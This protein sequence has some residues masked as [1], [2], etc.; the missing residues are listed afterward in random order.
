[1]VAAADGRRLL[2]IDD[3]ELVGMLVQTVAQLDGIEARLTV[4]PEDFYAA[5]DA[6]APTHV[7]LDM[8][9]PGCSGEELLREL[10]RRACRA[11]IVIAS[12]V[13]AQRMAQAAALARSLGLDFA[14]VLP[15]PFAPAALRALLQSGQGGPVGQGGP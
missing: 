14:G 2:I 12:G 11:R 3:D 7:V 10:A 5:L 4:R 1:M 13:D 9:L 15:K 6:D 8:T